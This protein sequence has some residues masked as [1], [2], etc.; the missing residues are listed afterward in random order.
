[1]FKT[2]RNVFLG[3]TALFLLL[4]LSR[5]VVSQNDKSIEL[6]EKQKN[7]IA[8]APIKKVEDSL[9]QC[10]NNSKYQS[11]LFRYSRHYLERGIRQN[12]DTI[13]YLANYY[14]ASHYFYNEYDYKTCL[15]YANEAVISAQKNQSIDGSVTALFLKGRTLFELGK[16]EEALTTY[17]EAETLIED[18]GLLKREIQSYIFI[19]EI[20]LRLK[21]YAEGKQIYNKALELLEKKI[22]IKK[23]DYIEEY[24]GTYFSALNGLGVC[25]RDSNEPVLAQEI[26]EKGLSFIENNKTYYNKQI[27][28]TVIETNLGKTYFDIGEFE[29]A[30]Q[31]LDTSR[32]FLLKEKDKS[33]VFF[34]NVFFT[35]KVLK[36]QAKSN[37]ALIALEEGFKYLIPKN[38]P[39]ELIEMYDMAIALSMEIGDIQKESKYRRLRT[40]ITDDIHEDNLATRWLENRELSKEN[41][42]LSSKNRTTTSN[43]KLLLKIGG[44]LFITLVILSISYFRAIKRNK[45]KFDTLMAK[46]ETRNHSKNIQQIVSITDERTEIILKKL[47][48]LEVSHFFLR[49]D[50]TLHSTAKKLKTNT[51]YLSKIINTHKEKNFKEYINELRI[52]YAIEQIRENPKFRLYTITAIAQE[53]GY[54]STN[55]F[56]NAFKK[57]T[58]LSIS[59][60][61]KQITKDIDTLNEVA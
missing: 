30:L 43:L 55:T 3:G 42:A 52:N 11:L 57:Y 6:T 8:Q 35:A 45:K 61:I 32:T 22:Y 27:L 53:L 7:F 16:Y 28:K 26:F 20:K 46:M 56:T 24:N 41:E 38:Y 14:L 40:E 18:T 48:R 5:E 36:E 29:Q 49:K 1:M 47:N 50:C 60:Y 12:N 31:L 39:P 58:G 25:Y 19:G 13:K 9:F 34:Q 37:E 33:N 44:I 4:F 15:R 21:K 23:Y 17:L 2:K 10:Y 51:S 54:K 59:Y